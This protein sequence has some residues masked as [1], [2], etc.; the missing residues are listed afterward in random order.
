MVPIRYRRP[1][2]GK[3]RPPYICATD[4]RVGPQGATGVEAAADPPRGGTPPAS[5]VRATSQ[6][7]QARTA[8][9]YPSELES[10]L[11]LTSGPSFPARF[12]LIDNKGE[13]EPL[14]DSTCSGSCCRTDSI[15]WTW[16]YSITRM[17]PRPLSHWHAPPHVL[18]TRCCLYLHPPHPSWL[19]HCALAK[20]TPCP[21]SQTPSSTFPGPGHATVVRICGGETT[22]ECI[23]IPPCPSAQAGG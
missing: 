13:A 14:T 10:R 19:V 7:S 6:A 18:P 22:E 12:D 5:H 20:E 9:D 15:C 3:S 21:L 11:A 8:R 17:M 1:E 2:C 23:W 4:C 16:N